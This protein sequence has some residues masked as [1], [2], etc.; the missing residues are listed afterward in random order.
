[1]GIFSVAHNE[2]ALCQS[3]VLSGD[4]WQIMAALSLLH[5][6]S[7]YTADN[8]FNLNLPLFTI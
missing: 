8:S 7:Y 3:V 6:P 2:K 4:P 1:M 5:Q